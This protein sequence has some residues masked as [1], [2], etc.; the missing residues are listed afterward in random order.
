M[1][2]VILARIG[3]IVKRLLVAASHDPVAVAVAKTHAVA[4]EQA[5]AGAEGGEHGEVSVNS[6]HGIKVSRL[7]SVLTSI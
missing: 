2:K 4:D 3:M 7:S 5:E 1:N 6:V